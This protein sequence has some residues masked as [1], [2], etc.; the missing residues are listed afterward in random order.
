MI[1]SINV[2]GISYEVNERTEKYAKKHIGRLDRY[3]PKGTKKDARAEIKLAQVN[4]DHGNKY[5]VKITISLIN[6]TFTASDST[7]NIMAAIDIVE[8]K[9]AEQMREYKKSLSPRSSGGKM[10]KAIRNRL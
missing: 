6:K 9:L 7:G 10:L 2:I 5:E 4:H 8:A 1:T 3:L